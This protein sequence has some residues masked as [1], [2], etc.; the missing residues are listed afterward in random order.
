MRDNDNG[1]LSPPLTASTKNFRESTHLIPTLKQHERPK[2]YEP[3]QMR[4]W[5]VVPASAFM[6]MLGIALEVALGISNKNHGFSVKEKNVF[7]FLSQ[8]FLTSFFPILFVA[9]LVLLWDAKNWLIKRYQ[10]YI[11]LS[12]GDASAENSLLL[13]YVSVNTIYCVWMAFTKRHWLVFISALASLSTLILQPLAGAIFDIQQLPE[14]SGSTAQSIR[15]LGL[16]PDRFQLT[17][18][19]AAAGYVLA[20]VSDGLLDPPFI[21]NNW[22]TADFKFPTGDYLNGTISVNTT[23]IRTNATCSAPTVLNLATGAPQY[24]ISSTSNAGCPVNVTFNPTNANQQYGVSGVD[25]CGAHAGGNR[26]FLPVFFWFFHTDAGAVGNGAGNPQAAGVFCTPT[27]EVF[28][29]AAN[30]SLSDGS[31]G[32]VAILSPVSGQ[33]NN[34]TGSPQNGI[35]FNGVVFDASPDQFTA[36]RANATNTGVPGAIMRSV[37]TNTSISSSAFDSLDG[38][39]ETTSRIYTQ[40]LA[41]VA[42]NTY[43]LP[44][45]ETF[46]ALTVSLKPRLV[47]EPLAGHALAIVL[48]VIGSLMLFVGIAHRHVRKGVFLASPPGSIAS[49]VALT[50]HSGFGMFLVPYDT[51]VGIASKLSPLLFSL[52]RRSGAIVAADRPGFEFSR[53]DSDPS[54]T[55][56]NEKRLSENVMRKRGASSSVSSQEETRM[57]LLGRNSNPIPLAQSGYLIEPFTPPSGTPDDRP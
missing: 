48:I 37:T 23:G 33:G 53:G 42:K 50:S 6:I 5:V 41:L 4:L 18:F 12:R 44:T 34:I 43:F 20:A 2:S 28:N 11:N 24:V 39:V 27:L 31:L 10:P 13:D 1:P 19:L 56:M 32:N 35:P 29:V 25:N 16:D 7:G 54:D 21:H 52:D 26:T 38:F 14:P 15:T 8:Q 55:E 36:A 46:L 49:A 30:A 45:E 47:I 57:S 17:A 3:P 40:H 51:D 9:P 22:T